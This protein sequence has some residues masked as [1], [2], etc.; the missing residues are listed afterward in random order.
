MVVPDGASI[1]RGAIWYQIKLVPEE[2]E[3]WYWMKLVPEEAEYQINGV[4]DQWVV[5]VPDQWST[6]W[7]C[8]RV[9][10]VRSINNQPFNPI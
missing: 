10:V 6:G 8:L 4:S 3:S 9:K 5:A 1:E 2:A 7:S